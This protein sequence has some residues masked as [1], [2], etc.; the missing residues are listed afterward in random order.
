MTLENSNNLRLTIN[1][2]GSNI[3]FGDVKEFYKK[4]GLP[5]CDY[6]AL[7]WHVHHKDEK[8]PFDSADDNAKYPFNWI[9]LY[10]G[11]NITK[12]QLENIINNHLDV[13][14]SFFKYSDWDWKLFYSVNDLEEVPLEPI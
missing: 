8:T 11:L 4:I 3:T 2:A 9:K 10:K 13:F 1:L 7:R 12:E 14:K 5:P 6:F